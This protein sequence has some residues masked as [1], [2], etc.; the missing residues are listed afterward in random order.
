LVYQLRPLANGVRTD[1]PVPD[2]PFVDDSHLPLD[3]GPEAIEA[4]GRHQGEGMWGRFD[5]DHDG[6]W[7]AFTTDPIRHDL[8]WVVR[9]HPQYGRTV[10]LMRDD[11]TAEMHNEWWGDPLLFRAGGYWWDGATWYRPGQIWDPVQQDYERRKA[12]AALTVTA[13]DLLDAGADPDRAH[14]ATIADFDPD[15][16][17]PGNW[18][19]HLALWAGLRTAREDARPLS[20]CVVTLASPELAADQL[21]GLQEM[22]ALGEIAASTL[23]AYIARD[24]SSVPLPQATVTGRG[25]WAKAVALDWSEAR[26]RS[27]EGVRAVISAGDRDELPPG[28]A[29]VRDRFAKDFFHSLWDRPDIRKRWVLRQRNATSV[30]EVADALAWSVAASLD[31][32]Q[33][34]NILGP[35][36]RHAVLDDFATGLDLHA[37][38]NRKEE[39]SWSD[40]TLTRPVARMLDWLIRHHPDSAQSTIGDILRETENRWKI[41]AKE[42]GRALHSSLSM[43]GNLDKAALA[44]YLKRVLPTECFS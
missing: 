14:V 35:T 42:T 44:E 39:I 10:L 41:P 43:D 5:G 40:L 22:A 8:G 26:R 13:E 2:L 20:Q 17:A 21:I 31:R 34:T 1:H 24:E 6:S 29:E 16:S 15:A 23:R 27:A 32:I 37:R 19:D 30:H 38:R 9:Y 11:E 25:L 3:E 36:I 12:A 4:V 33:P 28:A 18:R 7:R